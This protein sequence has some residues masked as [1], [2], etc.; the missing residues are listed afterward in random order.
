MV[1]LSKGATGAP[2]WRAFTLIELL[3]TLAIIALLMSIV[4][5]RYFSSVSKAEETVLSQNLALLRDAIDKHY[6]DTGKYPAS[7][8]DLVR[9]RYLRSMPMDPV[10]KRAD[11]WIVVPPRDMR[12]GAVYDVRSGAA[13]VARDGRPYDQW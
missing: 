4:A 3:V 9:K 13:G 12:T 10:A 1:A 8:E 6:A 2:R 11:A 5:P 7:L